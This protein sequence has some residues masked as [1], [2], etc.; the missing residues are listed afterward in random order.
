ML[1]NA[2]H[3]RPQKPQIMKML[4]CLAGLVALA[5]APTGFAAFLT[6]DQIIFQNVNGLNPALLS[7]TIDYTISAGN[8]SQAALTFR[9]TSPDAAFTDGSFPSAMLL[10]GFGLQ[11]PGVD[12]VG[13]SAAVASGSTAVNFGTHDITNL[14]DQYLFA[15]QSIDGYN[16]AGVLP[17]DTVV[18][19]VQNGQGT[20]FSDLSS[21]PSTSIDG[22]NFGAISSLETQFGSSQEGVRDSVR[23]ALNFNHEAPTFEQVQAGNVV[24]AF[25]SPDLIGQGVPDS[26]TTVMLLGAV[27]GITELVRRYL[28]KGSAAARCK[29]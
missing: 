15:N 28:L 3:P 27:L 1:R 17:V 26:G 23:I 9:N 6:V 2:S 20:L 19:S 18:S 8:T 10:T 16:N 21:P 14:S 11:L 22:P 5:V 7:G 25:G 4:K 12:I 29:I 24:L 13:A